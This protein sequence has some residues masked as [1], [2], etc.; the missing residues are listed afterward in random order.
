MAVDKISIS[1]PAGLSGPVR[2][3]A[4][5]AGMSLSSWFA[6]VAA[7][8]LRHQA[9]GEFLDDY[10]AEHGAFTAAEI[11]AA[12]RRLGYAPIEESAA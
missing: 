1:L 10:E 4:A 2:E 11:A 6:E 7:A 12:E 8:G 5:R 9:L 3:A